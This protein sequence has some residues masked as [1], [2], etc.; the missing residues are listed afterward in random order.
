MANA[1][2]PSTV[3][4]QRVT[5][6]IQRINDTMDRVT[7][8]CTVYFTRKVED[9]HDKRMEAAI[10]RQDARRS[11]EEMEEDDD[12]DDDEAE[13]VDDED[14][15]EEEVK[16]K[17][18]SSKK[19]GESRKYVAYD[20]V[21]NTPTLSPYARFTLRVVSTRHFPPEFSDMEVVR[22]VHRLRPSVSMLSLFGRL[23]K[24]V[25][26]AVPFRTSLQTARRKVMVSTAAEALAG[27]RDMYPGAA[28]ALEPVL[29]DIFRGAA[30]YALL[31]VANDIRDLSPSQCHSLLTALCSGDVERIVFDDCGVPPDLNWETMA[32]RREFAKLQLA[33]QQDDM[34]E[35]EEFLAPG[36]TA[37]PPTVPRGRAFM[38]AA[39]VWR[40]WRDGSRPLGTDAIDER[41]FAEGE[42]RAA[43]G[44]LLAC[45][46]V[47]VFGSSWIPRRTLNCMSAL[48]L[49]AAGRSRARLLVVV[50]AAAALPA[51]LPMLLGSEAMAMAVGA[52]LVLC[53]TMQVA[54]AMWMATGWNYLLMPGVADAA[55]Q[56]AV[57]AARLVVV[58][59]AHLFAVHEMAAVLRAIRTELKE[60]RTNAEL[61]LVL[62]GCAAPVHISPRHGMAFPFW[63]IATGAPSP[64][65]VTLRDDGFLTEAALEKSRAEDTA[66]SPTL[67]VRLFE[68]PANE[69]NDRCCAAPMRDVADVLLMLIKDCAAQGSPPVMVFDSEHLRRAVMEQPSIREYFPL[70]T[71]A[72]GAWAEEEDGGIRR[73]DGLWVRSAGGNRAMPFVSIA[74]HPK[75]AIRYSLQG[76]AARTM[77]AYADAPIKV[78]HNCVIGKTRFA[79]C[80]GVTFIAVFGQRDAPVRAWQ[81]RWLEHIAR[82]RLVVVLA[83]KARG[84]VVTLDD[85]DTNMYNLADRLMGDKK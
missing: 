14:E 61:H 41:K 55:L 60:G 27:L 83:G 33:P 54:K 67:N 76:G 5:A 24:I 43:G 47:A 62:A 39:H 78:H 50:G 28:T 18:T 42:S 17:K 82:G 12:D 19:T 56:A 31:G 10:R 36:A 57:S 59:E 80:D 79:P 49:V 25:P 64:G 77:A 45:G 35:F 70:N 84:L 52:T 4:V 69:P 48:R 1:I 21:V 46:A 37:K 30:H 72:V 68:V 58:A 26:W 8:A 32:M 20:S 16:A 66:V 51:R 71:A 73:I 29:C 65:Q 63:H 23:R 22:V 2:D 44:Y 34:G 13:E 53:P 7:F 9:T 75:T 6:R 38:Q 40:Q 15:E 85:V 3:K 74:D 11:G 81:L